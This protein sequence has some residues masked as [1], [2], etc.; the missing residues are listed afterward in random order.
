MDQLTEYIEELKSSNF[1]LWKQRMI[2][3]LHLDKY[4]ANENVPGV[5]K[6]RQATEEIEEQGNGV[7]ET[8]KTHP[9]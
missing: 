2:A 6:E 7:K 4:I 1:M 8:P 9:N 5:A 3:V